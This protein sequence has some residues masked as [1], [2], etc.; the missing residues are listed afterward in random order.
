MKLRILFLLVLPF[1]AIN[2]CQI[3]K[4]LD[5][6]K[7]KLE[8]KLEELRQ[9]N[10]L[11]GIN[12]SIAYKDGKIEDYALGEADKEENIPNDSKFKCCSYYF[13]ND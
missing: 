11:P 2:A 6:R 4:P 5:V 8:N 10:D 7:E 9:V 13:S 12:F 3:T 1:L